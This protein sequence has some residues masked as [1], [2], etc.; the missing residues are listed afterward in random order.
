MNTITLPVSD[1]K[2]ALPGFSK[3]IGK[4][5]TLPVLAHL[6]LTRDR[7]GGVSLA[8]TDLDA[9]A[10]YHLP[11]L[12]E[13]APLDLLVPFEPLNKLVKGLG[14]KDAVSFSLDGKDK[15]KLRYPLG[16]SLMDQ[17]LNSLPV[18][19]F[20]PLPKISQP[21]NPL[22]PEFGLAI[23]QALQCCCD[24]PSRPELQGACLDVEDKKAHYVVSA[25]GRLL[26]STNSFAFDLKKSITIPD[27]KFL[28]WTDLMDTG[29]TL[30]VEPPA[31]TET[32]GWIRLASPR[33][34]FITREI[35]RP[36][37]KWKQYV[38]ATINPNTVIKLS[39]AAIRQLLEVLPHLP[40]NEDP[41][42]P[43]RLKY[44]T[45]QLK[46]E[47]RGKETDWTGVFIQE[48][49]I[50]GKPLTIGV[51]RDYLLHALKFNL[52]E[53]QIED[54]LTPLVCVNAGKKMV[55]MPLKL[56]APP[57]T[58]PPVP[59]PQTST[60]PTTTKVP[61]SNPTPNEERKT[62]MPRTTVKPSA[63]TAPETPAASLIDQVEKIKDTLKNV[64]RDLNTLVDA[65]KLSEK[66][67]R[68]NDK[69]IESVRA[70][71]K[72]I[73]QVTI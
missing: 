4:R 10:I 33:W 53:I 59:A 19:E 35:D 58:K 51:N 18:A 34:T 15:L 72:K 48:V 71:L 56:D 44:E 60:T 61:A 46:V 31:K 23:K 67:Q 27:S 49:T 6:R 47:G 14:G 45:D 73:Q 69:E 57:T 11:E 41:N 36:F 25:N 68:A 3:I 20:P 17:T 13:G 39:D 2:T 1:L 28:S 43:I 8:A 37:P 26:F 65:V 29:C 55:I 9:H 50:T 21:D 30:A 70:T 64:V 38:P 12:Q 32:T 5:S 7:T 24:N 22:G 63:T 40:G 16:G 62:D 66:E 52:N 54:A 42:Q